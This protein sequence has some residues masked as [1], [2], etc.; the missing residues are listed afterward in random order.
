MN[1]LNHC[2]FVW[3]V[4]LLSSSGP[5]PEAVPRPPVFR[6]PLVP[7]LQGINGLQLVSLASG[8]VSC[9]GLGLSSSSYFRLFLGC[10]PLWYSLVPVLR[11][12]LWSA[13]RS[14]SHGA[15]VLRDVSLTKC[16]FSFVQSQPWVGL[17]SSYE[18]LTLPLGVHILFI[19]LASASLVY[20]LRWV[21]RV[22][23]RCLA[24]SS[25][26]DTGSLLYFLES[27]L[28]IAP[29]WSSDSWLTS[30]CVALILT[31]NLRLHGGYCPLL[32]LHLLAKYLK[33]HCSYGLHQ[34]IG[35]CDGPFTSC[36][37]LSEG[38][39]Y[40]SLGKGPRRLQVSRLSVIFHLR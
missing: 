19:L 17:F 16:S 35:L 14:V 3:A 11:G 13:Y 31:S 6:L 21:V 22:V 20:L 1:L 29:F 10:L 32:L 26:S 5:L 40:L 12:L 27:F 37:R 15:M 7:L 36:S 33:D 34:L 23:S 9:Q 28:F 24:A 39:L 18:N 2:I 30:L 38:T 25:D 8:C 4:P